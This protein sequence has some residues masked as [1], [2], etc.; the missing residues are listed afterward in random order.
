MRTDM[1]RLTGNI[2]DFAYTYSGTQKTNKEYDKWVFEA[3]CK[4]G[5]LEDLEEKLDVDLIEFLSEL[6]YVLKHSN[7]T[8]GYTSKGKEIKTDFGYVEEF[9][10]D[11]KALIKDKSE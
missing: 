2:G 1:S 11:L 4:L 10:E 7:Q 9:I 6:I 5:K 8:T 3:T